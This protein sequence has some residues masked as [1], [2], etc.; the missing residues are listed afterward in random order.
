MTPPRI[1]RVHSHSYTLPMSDSGIHRVL[2]FWFQQSAQDQPTIDSRMDRWF[3]VDPVTDA[4]IRGEFASLVDAGSRGELLPWTNSPQGRLALILVMDQFRRSI[5]RGTVREF[6]RDPEVLKICVEGALQGDHKSMDNFQ[7]A[8]FFMPLQHA[9]SR[10]IQARSVKLYS[11]LARSVSPTLL[12]T[13][14]TFAQF[15]EL[16]HDILEAFGR[17]PHRNKILGRANTPQETAYL[18]SGS[19]EFWR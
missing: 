17:F 15:A 10:T 6:S 12:A 14:A 19:G 8:F 5:Y 2:D 13:F 9:E 16:N 18:E 3:M 1:A 7:K 11:E 4:L